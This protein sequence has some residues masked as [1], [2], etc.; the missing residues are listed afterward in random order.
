MNVLEICSR[1]NKIR[2][3]SGVWAD[4]SGFGTASGDYKIVEAACDTCLP[5][6]LS[7]FRIQFPLRPQ[8]QRVDF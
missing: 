4:A 6:A 5:H 1:H 7:A 8:G 3:N 2:L